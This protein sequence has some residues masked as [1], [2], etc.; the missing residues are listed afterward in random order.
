MSGTGGLPPRPVIPQGGDAEANTKRL[1]DIFTHVPGRSAPD[2]SG[3]CA[4]ASTAETW[5]R[6]EMLVLEPAAS[7]YTDHSVYNIAAGS[8]AASQDAR[9][10][11]RRARRLPHKLKDTGFWRTRRNIR[12]R[13]GC[14]GCVDQRVMVKVPVLVDEQ[15]LLYLR[16]GILARHSSGKTRDDL[17][18]QPRPVGAVDKIKNAWVPM[19]RNERRRGGEALP[20]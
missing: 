19:T 2:N 9:Y 18:H 13:F 7:L 3:G 14:N 20:W 1:P 4:P 15:S 8:D 11:L 6:I 10:C 17:P 5:H 12:N 16:D